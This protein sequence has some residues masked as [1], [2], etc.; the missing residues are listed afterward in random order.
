MRVVGVPEVESV[1]ALVGYWQRRSD[2]VTGRLGKVEVWDQG[3]HTDRDG[4][5]HRRV[6]LIQGIRLSE[7]LKGEAPLSTSIPTSRRFITST[8]A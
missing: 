3:V 7:K 5:A 8:S 6:A 1:F 2:S 4:F